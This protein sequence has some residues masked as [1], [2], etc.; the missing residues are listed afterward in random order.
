MRTAKTGGAQVPAG[1]FGGAASADE[2]QRHRDDGCTHVV[3]TIGMDLGEH[4][5]MDV[6]R[7]HAGERDCYMLES[8]AGH[9][10]RERYSFVG[11]PCRERVEIHDGCAHHY[12][13]NA[14]VTT[15]TASETGDVADWL[16][17]FRRRYVVASPPALTRLN[18]GLVG[19]F[20]YDCVRYFEP[21]LHERRHA[22][23]D[24]ASAPG[25]PDIIFLVSHEILMHDHHDNST[26][27]LYV[28]P[29]T[30][31]DAWPRAHTHINGLRLKIE[32]GLRTL[33]PQPALGRAPTDERDWPQPQSS[34]DGEQHSAAVD[35]I[36]R[37]IHQ[38]DV[39]Q[40]VLSRSMSVPYTADPLEIYR[41]LRALNPSPYM[42]YF[43]FG[44]FQLTGSSPETLVRT[45]NNTATVRPLAGTRKRGKGPADD[46]ALAA[47]LLADEKERAEHLM[48][49]DL[50][51][52]DLGRVCQIGSVVTTEKMKVEYYSHVMH[53]VSNIVGRLAPD[54]NAFEVLKAAFP[55]GTLSGAPKIKAMEIIDE[56]EPCARG[57][58][59]GAVGYFAWNSTMNLAI[60]IRTALLKNGRLYFQAGGGIV[61]DSAAEVEWLETVNKGK[62]ILQ[63]VAAAESSPR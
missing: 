47:D 14:L 8:L 32:D 25:I 57:F 62:I 52:N 15:A 45:Q 1:V 13:D 50:G 33:P 23:D 11:L 7:L 2:F 24:S 22:F 30:G 36:K 48:L 37:R 6:L 28:A 16:H 19:Y 46:A 9:D 4:T 31:D 5:P 27:L 42:Y 43:N 26:H 34:L 17:R 56:L 54:H 55:A 59:G 29:V 49:I 51:R 41:Q 35:S 40:V 38:G 20:A 61:G 60:T 63:A 21:R 53:I 18:G 39:M 58:Y 3:L 10:S 12:R 44:G